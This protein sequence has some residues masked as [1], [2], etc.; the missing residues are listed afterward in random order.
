AD[1][2]AGQKW[3][4]PSVER[5]TRGGRLLVL[6]SNRGAGEAREVGAHVAVGRCA[7]GQRGGEKDL[8][9]SLA[10]KLAQASREP[11]VERRQGSRCAESL[12]EIRH[13]APPRSVT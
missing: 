1:Q 12:D 13:P 6:A 7:T 9:A 2:R 8:L 11:G 4:A 10:S 5:W 3:C